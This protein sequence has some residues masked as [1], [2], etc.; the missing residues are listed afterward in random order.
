MRPN[1]ARQ[2]GSQSASSAALAIRRPL[3]KSI[4]AVSWRQDTSNLKRV[5]LIWA[6]SNSACPQLTG[7]M[8]DA[9]VAQLGR[10]TLIAMC[11]PQFVRN[12]CD[13]V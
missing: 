10:C 13:S 4:S 6:L 3:D 7:P 1:E 2:P 8:E 9:Y 11:N 5:Y 12:E